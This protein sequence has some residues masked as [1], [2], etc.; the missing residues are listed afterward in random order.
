MPIP[1]SEFDSDTPRLRACVGS[2]GNRASFLKE[3]FHK[4]AWLPLLFELA[5]N[6]EVRLSMVQEFIRL[7]S[8]ETE[9]FDTEALPDEYLQALFDILRCCRAFAF[10]LDP[11]SLEF[12][13]EYDEVLVQKASAEEDR[14]CI[15]YNILAAWRGNS[16]ENIHMK[17]LMREIKE[18]SPGSSEHMAKIAGALSKIRGLTASEPNAQVASAALKD[19]AI[20]RAKLRP[21]ATTELEKVLVDYIDKQCL[22]VTGLIEAPLADIVAAQEGLQQCDAFIE[23]L[24]AGSETLG[25]NVAWAVKAADL[26]KYRPRVQ[27]QLAKMRVGKA[28]K[29]TL[30]QCESGGRF[31]DDLQEIASS[32]SLVGAGGLANMCSDAQALLEKVICAIGEDCPSEVVAMGKVLVE[33]FL[34]NE[35]A[36]Q[37]SVAR[38][39]ALSPVPLAV[40]ALAGWPELGD[41]DD[42]RFQADYGNQHMI[43]KTLVRNVQMLTELPDHIKDDRVHKVLADLQQVTGNAKVAAAAMHK[44]KVESA[45]EQNG[46]SKVKLGGTNGESWMERLQDKEDWEQVLAIAT[47]TLMQCDAGALKQTINEVGALVND[48]AASLNIFDGAAG[49]D[50]LQSMRGS[51]AEAWATFHTAIFIAHYQM[52]AKKPVKL[53]TALASEERAML[54]HS[55]AQCVLPVVLQKVRDG[56]DLRR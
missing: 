42:K 8:K 31:S 23:M 24:N 47:G 25:R 52:W 35:Q 43:V 2:V 27:S 50:W 45:I 1:A 22:L 53:K 46:F 34:G 3:W 5:D 16:R 55:C 19:L 37:G 10:C 30:S 54:A 9:N 29:S 17:G 15:G 12:A 49:N 28:L 40:A 26:T 36:S 38:F 33:S 18:F 13:L 11:A 51:M 14:D 56:I 32:F 4:H 44:H 48:A 7:L 39:M 6:K 41:S 21:G 20:M